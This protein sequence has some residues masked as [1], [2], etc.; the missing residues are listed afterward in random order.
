MIIVTY[1][2]VACFN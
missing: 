2:I 1:F